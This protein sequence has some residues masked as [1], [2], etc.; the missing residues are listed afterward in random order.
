MKTVFMIVNYNDYPSTKKLIDNIKEYNIIDYILVV[1]NNSSDDSGKKLNRLKND[2]LT[3]ISNKENK[4]YSSAINI[5]SKYLIDKYQ[6]CNIIISNADII[7]NEENDLINL[8]QK[9]SKKE[10]GVVAPTILERGNLNRGWKQP[11]P[12]LECALN[13]PYFHKLF[14]K[15]FQNYPDNY[16]H[17]KTSEVDVVSGCFFLIKSKVMEEINFLDE[18]VFLYYEENILSAKIKQLNKKIIIDNQ[19]MIVHNHSVTINK[20]INR[21]KK[22]KN[23]KRSQYYFE[24]NYNN[25]NIIELILLK[26]TSFLTM[27]ILYC[28]YF[29]QDLFSRMK[30]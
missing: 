16:Y 22:Y 12:L 2:K 25:A 11:T 27:L 26:I 17:G 28:F 8:I 9:L 20:N 7:I 1:D 13:I 10:I 4:G 23:Q 29:L 14:R 5:G 6:E 15:R 21:I 18:N 19:T 30:G 24:K 3:V